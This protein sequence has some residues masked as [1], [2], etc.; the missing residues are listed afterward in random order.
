MLKKEGAFA[1]WEMNL[2][3]EKT[4]EKPANERKKEYRDLLT[5]SDGTLLPGLLTTDNGWINESSNGMKYWRTILF[6]DI[7]SFTML[8]LPGQ[9]IAL[10]KRL[11]N[12]YKEG[13]AYRYFS[14]E[15]MKQV[16]YHSVSK[17][18]PYCFLKAVCTPSQRV[19]NTP[20]FVW[21]C[22]VKSTGDIKSAFCP[23][24]AG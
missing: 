9:D 11:L 4:I 7:C 23:C 10:S 18:S 21:I 14:N 3:I 2:P 5:M 17:S 15:W 24:T 19:K 6:N 12:G 22:T 16:H 1:A 20:H 13:K 8:D